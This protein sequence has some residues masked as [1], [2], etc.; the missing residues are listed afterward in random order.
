MHKACLPLLLAAA[1][2]A[3]RITAQNLILNGDFENTTSVGCDFNLS[4][5]DFT[6]KMA[7]AVGYGAANE[8]DIMEG[9]TC[10]GSSAQSGLKK[11]GIACKLPFSPD[12]DELALE[13]AQP[14]VPGQS[15]RLSFW[16]E[17]EVFS[18]SPEI[19][20][21]EIGVST[22]STSFG[23]LVFAG[24]GSAGI[25]TQLQTTFTAPVAATWLTIRQ[26]TNTD[27]WNHIDNFVLEPAFSLTST[28]SCPGTMTFSV[29]GETPGG[30][31]AFV[32]GVP[33]SFT[34]MGTP[35]T[36]TTLDIAGPTLAQYSAATSITGNV[37]AG[38]CGRIRVQA[39]DVATCAVSNFLDL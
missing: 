1:F 37:P 36:G 39:V 8:I 25:W 29:S 38:A 32:Y 18:F 11:V 9:T 6:S 31:V 21:V 12:V 3:P 14:L 10:Y 24:S 7:N 34:W 23:T 33:G 22:S 35:C 15:Y 28:G 19:A 5:A 16:V 26:E 30:L 27:S 4:N 13:L 2:L 17:A 20:D